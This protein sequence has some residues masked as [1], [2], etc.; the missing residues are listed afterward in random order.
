MP[1]GYELNLIAYDSLY[2][3]KI[4]LKY[5]NFVNIKKTRLEIKRCVLQ[6]VSFI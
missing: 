4:L 1:K 3:L 2:I 6:F 5:N